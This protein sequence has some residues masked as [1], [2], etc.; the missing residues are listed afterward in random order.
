M[1][2]CRSERLVD[3]IKIVSACQL[4]A[5]FNLQGE[6]CSI[7]EINNLFKKMLYINM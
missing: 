2:T 5:P 6:G 4:V 3:G 1:R 7:F